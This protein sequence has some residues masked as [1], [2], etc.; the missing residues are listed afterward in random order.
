MNPNGFQYDPQ[1]GEWHF[2][3]SACGFMLYAPSLPEMQK[4]LPIHTHSKD[5]LGGW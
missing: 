5:C 2:R 4:A 1:A 3:C